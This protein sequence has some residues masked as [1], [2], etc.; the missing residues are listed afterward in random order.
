[1]W[2]N[3]PKYIV[4]LLKAWFGDA[5]SEENG[6]LFDALPRPS[7]DPSHIPTVSA[8]ADGAVKGYFLMGENPTVGSMHGALHR[9]AMRKLDWLGVRD[10]AGTE[11]ADFWRAAPEI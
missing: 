8:M 1:W 9:A 7:G 2:S 10:F 6:W 3:F 4:S 11:A 5:A